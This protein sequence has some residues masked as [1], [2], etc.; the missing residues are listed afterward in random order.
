MANDQRI[1]PDQGSRWQ[2]AL[3]LV[4]FLGPVLAA[5]LI[6]ANA[7]RWLGGAPT[8]Q[9]GRLYQPAEPLEKLP[10]TRR[11]GQPLSLEW[12]RGKW[13]VAVIAPGDCSAACREA[14]Y[15]VRQAHKAQG[16][17]IGRVQ[18]LYVAQG[19]W[20][21]AQARAF[22]E[23]EHPHLTVARP[24][25]GAAPLAAWAHPGAEGLPGIY[26]LDPPANLVLRYDLGAGA[27]G[28]LKDLE[29]LLKHS[30][31]G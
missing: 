17:N 23:A 14:L 9:H 29:S 4:V 2:L 25:V 21:G 28:I 8:G 10:L 31:I 27:K 12:L 6:Y 1:H 16:K 7:E 3:V 19:A 20:P 24:E 18:R 26:V 15:K 30:T 13:T 11:D 5:I 22:L